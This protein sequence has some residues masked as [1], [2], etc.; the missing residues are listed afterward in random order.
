MKK[1]INYIIPSIL[2][3][4]I[5]CSSSKV[6]TSNKKE[7]MD[8]DMIL[9]SFDRKNLIESDTH[10][11]W[12]KK[13]YSLET[14]DS[15]V[16]EKIKTVK[17]NTDEVLIFLGT[18]CIDSRYGVP[19]LLQILDTVGIKNIKFVGLDRDKS[20]DGEDIETK[21]NIKHVPTIIFFKDGKERNRI[22]ESP[23]DTW[24]NDILRI[25]VNNDYLPNYS[26]EVK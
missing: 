23:I 8:K 26:N 24:E 3:F 2:L 14:M 22:I 16:I 11:G 6:L 20:S 1:I 25:L 7:D 13:N 5:S 4:S 17:W 18:W 9:G 12:F 21:Y 15:A 19:A 10:S